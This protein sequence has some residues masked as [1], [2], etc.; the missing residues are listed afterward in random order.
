MPLSGQ[1][2][3]V[4]SGGRLRLAGVAAV[5]AACI[6]FAAVPSAHAAFPGENGKIVY[7]HYDGAGPTADGL[8]TVNAN[9]SGRAF[10]TNGSVGSWSPDGAEVAYTGGGEGVFAIKADGT[11]Q[12]T[13][14]FSP[15]N[16][17]FASWSPDG[18]QVLYTDTECDAEV[19]CYRDIWKARSDGS[20]G[21]TLLTN[22]TLG[23]FN[24]APAWSPNGQKIALRE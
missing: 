15:P 23:E 24:S 20:G 14:T 18:S 4:R 2:C 7:W 9:G 21:D 10:L 12:R 16:A 13:I 11:G 19:G 8:H 1:S 17:D 6:L 22:A 5:L 3:Q